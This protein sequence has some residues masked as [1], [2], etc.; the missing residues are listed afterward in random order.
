VR[1]S[2]A[3]SIGTRLVL[4]V[5]TIGAVCSSR[6]AAATSEVCARPTPG[7]AVT[8]PADLTS[9]DGR[10]KIALR[11]RSDVD[12]Q[13]RRRYCYVTDQNKLAP[14][15][16]VNPGDWLEISLKNEITIP[17]GRE[18]HGRAV[19]KPH[20]TATAKPDDSCAGG[21]MIDG[22]T[23]LHFH[24]LSI[25]PL[26]HQDDTLHTLV[27]PGAPAFQYR[28]RIPADTPPGLYWYHPHPH[29]FAKAQVLGGASGALI[30]QGI[31]SANP[32]A[33]GLPER[34]WVIRDEE[35]LNPQATPVVTGSMPAPIV[36]RDA[37]GD[38]LNSGTGEG[39]PAKDLSVNFVPVPFPQYP[40]ATLT[41][42][43]E[44]RELW[45]VLNA[46]A[47]T[48]LDLQLLFDGKAQLLS[49]VALDGSPTNV[50]TGKPKTKPQA[51][52]LVPPGG[53]VEFIVTGPQKGISANLVTRRV[54]TGP[55]G[56]NDPTRP[57]IAIQAR[58]D[59]PRAR[60]LPL[61]IGESRAVL[62]ASR[63][64]T[65]LPAKPTWIGDVKAVR[66]RHL[67]FFEEPEDPKNPS[68]PTKFYLTI[69]GHRNRQ[70]DPS[71]P[72]PDMI[73]QQGTVEDWI[74]ENRTKELHAFHIHQIH[75]IVQQRSGIPVDEP[76]LRDTV[77]VGYWDGF[78][79]VYP[80]LR[81]RM[82]FRDPSIVG[83]FAYHCHLL[84]HQ[85]GGMM[86]TIRV[87]GSDSREP[88]KNSVVE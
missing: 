45:R 47:I 30:V 65:T 52:A 85:D 57:L 23:N 81:L 84:E 87:Q 39:K 75:F 3:T 13:G 15:L 74:I 21:I 83:T 72:L 62:V 22:A 54:D 55:A 12:A 78:S 38:I 70:F 80:S 27:A 51:H 26:C 8:Q 77:N 69:E 66:E 24:G 28:I 50:L 20:S 86:G 61:A 5:L 49:V 82:D 73:V 18:H 48:Y 17:G 25:P 64:S 29:G 14:T 71:Q 60:L 40:P 58:D 32:V 33:A 4:W 67:F 44:Q 7:S 37:E 68:S 56:E 10:L 41:V 43:P 9:V 63:S 35:L 79:P 34:V 46:S 16:R 11:I 88:T 76:Y 6:A 1:S 19:A 53:R 42:G 36:L 59:A 2:S 31:E